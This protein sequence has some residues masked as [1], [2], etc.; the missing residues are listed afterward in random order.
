M[1]TS[2][3]LTQAHLQHIEGALERLNERIARLAQL[4]DVS[5]ASEATRLSILDGSLARLSDGLASITSPDKRRHMEWEELR[6][7][8]VLRMRLMKD[9]LS[10][11]GLEP[12]LQMAKVVQEHMTHE[13]FKAG[14]D[15]FEM[16]RR[17]QSEHDRRQAPK[18]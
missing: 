8:M 14:S 3:D 11:M 9:T 10:E 12:T 7:L 2:P 16:L 5:L 17:L 6:A 18:P 4:L 15:G 1:H 13:G